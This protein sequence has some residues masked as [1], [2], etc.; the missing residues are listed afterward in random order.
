MRPHISDITKCD[1]HFN[2]ILYA[3]LGILVDFVW[4]L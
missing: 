1:L 2:V 4:H 3:I